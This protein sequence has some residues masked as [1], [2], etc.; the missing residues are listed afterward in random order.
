MDCCTPSHVTL[1]TNSAELSESTTGATVDGLSG[2]TKLKHGAD[3][4][5]IYKLSVNFKLHTYLTLTFPHCLPARLHN[6][7][8]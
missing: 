6:D 1:H 5:V 7:T 3:K 2:L 8:S 4:A